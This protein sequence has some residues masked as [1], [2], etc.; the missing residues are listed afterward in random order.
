MGQ[1]SDP[2]AANATV[3]YGNEECVP[4]RYET[5][6]LETQYGPAKASF[7]AQGAEP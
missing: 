5:A 1:P 7:E 2:P 3:P 6:N 4:S